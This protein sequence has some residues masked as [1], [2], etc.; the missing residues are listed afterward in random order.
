MMCFVPFVHNINLI[1]HG[2]NFPNKG[3]EVINISFGGKPPLT[4]TKLLVKPASTADI[5]YC[6]TKS[7]L[8]RL[9]NHRQ[10]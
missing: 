10:V 6:S 1:I 8:L 3:L 5:T 7:A 2:S 9:P 4:D